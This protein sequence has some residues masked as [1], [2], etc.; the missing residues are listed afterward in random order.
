MS[1]IGQET[2]VYGVLRF[3][4]MQERG[5]NLNSSVSVPFDVIGQTPVG[6][7]VTLPLRFSS[8]VSRRKKA[9][10][11]HDSSD[12]VRHKQ[13]VYSRLLVILDTW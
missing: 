1:I 9:L 4:T 10:T 3:I 7:S 6:G 2:N 5:H 13:Y 12:S 11:L 8:Y